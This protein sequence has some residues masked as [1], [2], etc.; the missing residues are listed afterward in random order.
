MLLHG[1]QPAL[2]QASIDVVAMEF[3]SNSGPSN[4]RVRS[5]STDKSIES[6]SAQKPAEPSSVATTQAAALPCTGWSSPSRA[7]H[8]RSVASMQ[9]AALCHTGGGSCQPW[10]ACQI[11]CTPVRGP[12]WFPRSC[13]RRSW[14]CALTS[15]WRVDFVMSPADWR[16]LLD[17]GVAVSVA[18][19]GPSPYSSSRLAV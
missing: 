12:G 6:G 11:P 8:V 2:A 7:Q 5:D 14:S 13:S 15:S 18:G 3:G 1:G 19:M 17:E 4:S 10:S 16:P 9:C